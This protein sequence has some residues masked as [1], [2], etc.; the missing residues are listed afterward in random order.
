LNDKV[1]SYNAFFIV[2]G[3]LSCISLA[4]LLKLFNEDKY[5]PI[6]ARQIQKLEE[7]E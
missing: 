7:N 3:F 2:D 6:A 1:S 4:I 5:I